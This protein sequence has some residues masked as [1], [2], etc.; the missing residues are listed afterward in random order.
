MSE[1][2]VQDLTKFT[3][4]NN[5]VASIHFTKFNGYV[6]VFKDGT[7]TLVSPKGTVTAKF[8]E[9]EEQ[10]WVRESYI[11]ALI[12]NGISDIELEKALEAIARVDRRIATEGDSKRMQ[13]E[14]EAKAQEKFREWG[15]K[16]GIDLTE[17]SEEQIMEL[18]NQAV[19]QARK[20]C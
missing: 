4:S 2:Q 7:V 11:Q 8:R 19:H 17:L 12:Q 15:C 10:D 1:Y 18:I 14:M 20:G 13:S 6:R 3:P 16:Q 5:L 9:L